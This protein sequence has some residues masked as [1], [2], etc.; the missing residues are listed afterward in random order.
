MSKL[1]ITSDTFFGRSAI[2][3]M[4]GRPYSSVEEMDRDMIEKWN[5]AIDQDDNIYHLGNFAWSPIVADETLRVL[6]GN[7]Y[8]ILGD[9]DAALLEIKDY[10]ENITILDNQIIKNPEFGIVLSHWPLADW[11]GKDKG[12]FSFHGHDINGKQFKT[13]LNQMNR[14]NICCDRWNYKPQNI[15]D[16]F[17]LF[18]DFQKNR[19]KTLKSE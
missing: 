15:N 19:I 12:A 7:K 1:F 11:P 4:A 16:L 9:Y 2:I 5:S 13:D 8:F 18:K 17:E 10:H 6:N 3:K 14:V